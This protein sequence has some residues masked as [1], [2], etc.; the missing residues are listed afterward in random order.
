MLP[1]PM[2]APSPVQGR[3]VGTVNG[4]SIYVAE[5]GCYLYRE[6]DRWRDNACLRNAR[7]GLHDTAD[8]AAKH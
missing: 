6:S 1:T 2:A 7:D 4:V 3:Y 5:Q 8:L